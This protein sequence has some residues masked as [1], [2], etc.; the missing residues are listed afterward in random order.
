MSEQLYSVCA[1]LPDET[2]KADMKAFFG[3]MHGT[4]NHLLLVDQLWLAHFKSCTLT[5]TR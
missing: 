3:S 4:L 1:R 5:S 2:R